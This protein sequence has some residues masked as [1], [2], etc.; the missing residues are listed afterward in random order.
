M[1]RNEV[2]I[3]VA[4][5]CFVALLAAVWLNDRRLVRLGLKSAKPVG[6]GIIGAFNELFHPE[7]ARA[8]EILEVQREL[9]AEDAVPSDPLRRDGAITIQLPRDGLPRDG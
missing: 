1:S 3:A 9:P 7:A 6:N 8:T 4:L 2:I 5:A